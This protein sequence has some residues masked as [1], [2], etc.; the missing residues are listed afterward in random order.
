M[1]RF[2]THSSRRLLAVAALV[3]ATAVPSV[4]VVS[5]TAASAK[6]DDGVV[7]APS[8]TVVTVAPDGS[9]WR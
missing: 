9:K 7:S 8:T 1:S 6:S 3:T 4:L 5:Q 2:L